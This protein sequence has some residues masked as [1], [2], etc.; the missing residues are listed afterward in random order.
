METTR[1]QT[2]PTKDEQA[3]QHYILRGRLDLSQIGEMDRSVPLRVAAVRN[4]LV[5]QSE[6]IDLKDSKELKSVEFHL[7]FMLPGRRPCGVYLVVGRGDIKEDHLPA[8]EGA[9]RWIAANQWKE[10]SAGHNP[11]TLDV[12]SVTILDQ[13]YRDW[14]AFCRRYTIRGR[15]VCRRWYYDSIE[16]QWVFVDEPVPGA[17][18]EA[19]DVDYWWWWS[20]RD[21]IDTAIT[22][23]DGTFS[24]T[25]VWCCAPWFPR[26]IP[27]MIDPDILRRIREVLTQVK[28]PI[29]LPDPPDPFQLQQYLSRIA[30]SAS[31]GAP[32]AIGARVLASPVQAQAPPSSA[33]ALRALLP[34]APELEALHVWPWWFQRDCAPDVVFRV[35]QPC[36]GEVRVIYGEANTQT[37]W[38]IPQTLNVTLEANDQA[39]CL[40][41]PPEPPCGDC[42]VFTWVSCVR[43]DSIGTSSGPPDLRGY[44]YPNSLDRPFGGPLRIRGD[45]GED[46]RPIV[47]FYRI[48]YRKDSMP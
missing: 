34:S 31:A 46:A 41:R 9:K 20:F 4:N 36:G 12:G 35:T 15:V 18:V 30:G 44:A 14:L 19:Y 13:V 10:K 17:T 26:P 27:W 39:C 40:P 2:E 22:A 21:Q 6:R 38:N 16:Q 3:L 28:L 32:V 45:F 23:A 5:I 29:P 33:S 48:E 25:F 11:F 24:M 37:R 1:S 42:L 47:D 43:T 8:V 7:E